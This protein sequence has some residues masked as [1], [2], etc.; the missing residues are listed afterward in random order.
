MKHAR[1]RKHDYLVTDAWHG[2]KRFTSAR[3]ATGRAGTSLPTRAHLDFQLCHARA[4]D[5]IH[6]PLDVNT[7]TSDLERTGLEVIRL[8]SQAPDRPTYLQRPD[9]GRR[10]DA[11]SAALLR[12][13]AGDD[14]ASDVALVV[15]DGLS[16]TAVQRHAPPVLANIVSRLAEAGL[17]HSPVCLVE[18]GRVAVGDEIGELLGARMLVLLV[19]ERPGL[20]APD[21]LGIYFT[22]RPGWG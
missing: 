16:S 14:R 20:S 2:L 5:A 22:R 3:I 12:Q 8:H 13:R 15:A 10:L 6:I 1:D 18:Q 19:G 4:R 11:A 9:L 17:R 21:S 7:L